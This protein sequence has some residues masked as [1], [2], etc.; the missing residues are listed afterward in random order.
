LIDTREIAL[1]FKTIGDHFI[2]FLY[3]LKSNVR[4]AKCKNSNS[5]NDWISQGIA[6]DR[7]LL[8]KNAEILGSL[9]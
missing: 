3:I 9:N 6:E 1:S 8:E 5:V 4:G 2:W 7:P